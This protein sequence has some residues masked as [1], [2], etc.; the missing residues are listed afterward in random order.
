MLEIQNNLI[1]FL[2]PLTINRYLQFF[3]Q[4]ILF[5]SIVLFI[6]YKNSSA[7]EALEN[8]LTNKASL[9]HATRRINNNFIIKTVCSV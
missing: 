5:R 8:Q 1:F 6:C 9:F 7:A 2:K 3:K 4:M